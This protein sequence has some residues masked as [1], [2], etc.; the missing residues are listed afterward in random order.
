MRVHFGG[1]C[2]API[3]ENEGIYYKWVTVIEKIKRRIK[4]LGQA[5]PSSQ[6]CDR[7]KGERKRLFFRPYFMRG[8]VIH[9]VTGNRTAE[10]T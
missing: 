8:R 5:V 2:M 9:K 6:F 3:W 4:A 1:K 10:K 7:C